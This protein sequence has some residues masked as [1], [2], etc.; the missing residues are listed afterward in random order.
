MAASTRSQD[1]PKESELDVMVDNG[2]D[3]HKL[4]VLDALRRIEG[5][6]DTLSGQVTDLRTEVK[7]MQSEGKLAKYFGGLILPASVALGVSWVG[8]RLGL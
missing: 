8:R 4:L 2:W 3:E 1:F 7:V 5:K 6:Q